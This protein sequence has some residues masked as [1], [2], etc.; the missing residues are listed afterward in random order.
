L[1]QVESAAQPDAESA[2]EQPVAQLRQAQMA[3][4]ALPVAVRQIPASA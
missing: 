3:A 1:L 4:L 2:T